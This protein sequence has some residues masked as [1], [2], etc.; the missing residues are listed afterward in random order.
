MVIETEWRR[1]QDGHIKG[2]K[3]DA[4]VLT[5]EIRVLAKAKKRKC[6][7]LITLTIFWENI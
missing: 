6:K 2:Q 4:T 7:R 3:E 5:S 1:G